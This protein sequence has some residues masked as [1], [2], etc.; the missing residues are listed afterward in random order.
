MKIEVVS[1]RADPENISR[2]R[3]FA[4]GVIQFISDGKSSVAQKMQQLNQ[5]YP[6]GI[7]LSTD[8]V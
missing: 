5:K 1:V 3:R 7:R 4:V 6:F 2:L 8:D